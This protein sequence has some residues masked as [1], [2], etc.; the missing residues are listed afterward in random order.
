MFLFA[1]I[2][3]DRFWIDMGA[4]AS[5]LYL[6]RV[7]ENLLGKFKVGPKH[8]YHIFPHDTCHQ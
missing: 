6:L 7:G 2:M 5:N 3:I 4:C 8:I 1:M